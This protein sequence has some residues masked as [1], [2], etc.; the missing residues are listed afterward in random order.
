VTGHRGV[1][2]ITAFDASGGLVLEQEISVAD[3]YEELHPVIDDD[4]AFRMQRHVRIVIGKIYAPDGRLDQEFR[5]EYD[6]DGAYIR[7]RIAYADGTV[8]ES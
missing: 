5:N 1:A 6:V 7:S 4:A 2:V 8:V 3:Y